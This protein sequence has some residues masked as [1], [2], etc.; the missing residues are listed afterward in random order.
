MKRGARLMR[1]VPGVMAGVLTVCLAAVAV[2]CGG[3]SANL[4]SFYP[5]KG[6]VTLPDGKT[7]SGVKVVFWGPTSDS[8][9]TESDGTFAFKG[10]KAGLPVGDYKVS[11]EI[12][13]SAKASAKAALPFPSRY[14]DEDLSLLTAKVTADGPNDFDFK[15][16]K[17]GASTDRSKGSGTGRVKV[18]D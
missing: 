13:Q 18:R 5:V 12:T 15:L 3:A 2:G 9:I 17:E 6:R 1:S 10:Q 8:A 7:M 16:T 4:G 14:L 11:L